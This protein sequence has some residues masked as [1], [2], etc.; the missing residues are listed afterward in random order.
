MPNTRRMMMAAAGADVDVPTQ[1][2]LWSSGDGQFGQT[3]IGGVGDRTTMA[4]MGGDDATYV[5]S[6]CG[7]W[8]SW[9]YKANGTLWTWGRGSNGQHGGGNTTNRNSPV[10]VGSLTNWC[11]DTQASGTRS[12]NEFTIHIKT[13]GTAWVY[14]GNG[15]YQ[16]GLG[17]TTN[18]SSPVQI[19]SATNWVKAGGSGASSCLVNS[20]GEI[21]TCGW[22]EITGECAQ[23]QN[24]S[25]ITTPTKVGSLTTWKHPQTNSGNHMICSKTDGTMWAWGFGNQGRLGLNNTTNYS[26]PVQIGSL[27]NWGLEN[28][29][30]AGGNAHALAVKQ[31]GTLWVWGKGGEGQLGLGDTTDRSS[32]VQ[33]GTATD[34]VKVQCGVYHSMAINT[35][36]KLYVWGFNSYSYGGPLGVGDTTHRSS[37]VQVAGSWVFA[38]G[39][40][41]HS[42]AIKG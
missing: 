24:S 3:G 25:H 13:D 8:G 9:A 42:I 18:Y 39:G 2:E 21:Y 29:Q 11:G 26:S 16:L 14:G 36:G 12:G 34:W 27:T 33:V 30:L 23:G 4:L 15:Y 41:A 7:E 10:Q 20:S 6:G 5:R 35:K 19:G 28:D 38:A 37:P 17:N 31:D 1:G 32:P 40:Y 22:N